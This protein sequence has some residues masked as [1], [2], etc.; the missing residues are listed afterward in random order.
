MEAI[1]VFT[2]SLENIAKFGLFYTID[3][4]LPNHELI[5]SI[6]SACLAT[7]VINGGY[8]SIYYEFGKYGYVWAILE[9]PFVFL[10]TVKNL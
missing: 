2:M 5:S 6:L 3:P 10:L 8:T 7:W 1:P 4:C 9:T